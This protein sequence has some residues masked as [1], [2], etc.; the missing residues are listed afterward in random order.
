MSPAELLEGQDETIEEKLQRDKQKFIQLQITSSYQWDMKAFVEFWN[1]FVLY[2]KTT[3]KW[4][5]F[6]IN[7]TKIFFT[8]TIYAI[9]SWKA[10]HFINSL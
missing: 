2:T 7:R 1:N 3:S 4:K 5:Q 10:I 8:Y 6:H 9:R